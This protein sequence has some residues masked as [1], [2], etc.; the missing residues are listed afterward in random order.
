M[1]RRLDSVHITA[2]KNKVP[3]D[4]QPAMVTSG[5]RLGSPS[6][7][8]RG[9]LEEDMKKVAEM[10]YFTAT[11]YESKSDYIRSEVRSLCEKHPIYN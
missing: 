9:Y 11:D 8:S 4:P 7:T 6:V 2:N 3:D 10:I 1:E 5:I